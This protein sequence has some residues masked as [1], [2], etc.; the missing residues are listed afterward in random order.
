M[1]ILSSSANMFYQYCFAYRKGVYAI[2]RF[3]QLTYV[4]DDPNMR[5]KP[6]K[7]Y[8]HIYLFLVMCRLQSVGF[9][10]LIKELL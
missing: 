6:V 4:W 2:G 7:E 3:L 1:V 8:K 10:L 9:L 5:E